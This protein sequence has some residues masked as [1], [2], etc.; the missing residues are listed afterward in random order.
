MNAFISQD[1][2]IESLM[3]INFSSTSVAAM[4]NFLLNAIFLFLFC[5]FLYVSKFH[6]MLRIS[7]KYGS[8]TR[9]KFLMKTLT[10]K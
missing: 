6:F 10:L 2:I 9:N 7:N 8:L 5:F 3:F 4:T 1:R